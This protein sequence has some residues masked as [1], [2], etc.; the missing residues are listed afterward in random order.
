MNIAELT[1][2]V[3][4]TID[5]QGKVKA[6]VISPLLWQQI[7][8][9]LEDSVDR[10]LVQSFYERLAQHPASSGALRWEDIEHEWQ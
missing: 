2:D 10:T 7:I 4:F 9:L 3:H 1:K 5:H 8:A 6:V